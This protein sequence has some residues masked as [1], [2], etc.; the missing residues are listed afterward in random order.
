MVKGEHLGH[1]EQLVLWALVRLGSNAYGVTVRQE[2][3]KRSGRDVSI[4]AVYTTLVRLEKKGFVSSSVGEATSERGGRAK[5]YFKITAPGIR[6]LEDAR[7]ILESMWDALP[8][9]A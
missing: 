1:F 9:G 2:L 7:S 3:A 4:G 8:A 5:R 6:A